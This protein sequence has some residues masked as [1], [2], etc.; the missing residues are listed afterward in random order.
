MAHI[1]YLSSIYE[2]P[3][4]SVADIGAGDGAFSR[5][6]DQ[7]GAIVTGI[8]I[9]PSKVEAARKN[10]PDSV[11][12]RAGSGEA[13]PLKDSSIDLACFFFSFH[14]VPMNVQDRALAEVAR[15]LRPGGR[16]HVV[17]PFPYGSMFEVVRLVED[18]TEVRT[19]S[20]HLMRSL[21]EIGGFNLI[22]R[23]E[24]ELIREYPD[25]GFFVEKIVSGDPERFRKYPF[26]KEDMERA[27]DHAIGDQNGKRVLHQPCAAYHF[28]VRS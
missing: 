11:D 16:L 9:D 25:F 26:V 6:M 19:H 17:E 27:Y 2:L 8:E 23:K 12:I 3:G 24:Y 18:E 5:Q 20:H 1:E 22:A 4:R 7:A 15:V 28:E 10:L 21:P 14:H 13:L